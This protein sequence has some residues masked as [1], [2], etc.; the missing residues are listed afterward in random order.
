MGKEDR[1]DDRV[2]QNRGPSRGGM[3]APDQESNFDCVKERDPIQYEVDKSLQ[4]TEYA[5]HDP[6]R[7]PLGVI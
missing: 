2:V 3:H 5:I 1:S 6:V 4:K 7:Q